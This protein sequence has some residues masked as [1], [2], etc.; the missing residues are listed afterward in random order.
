MRQR[1][2]LVWR[3]LVMNIERELLFGKSLHQTALVLLVGDI[4]LM[5][6]YTLHS[7]WK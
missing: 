3:P 2:R 5:Y 6:R 1:I 7:T 4:E